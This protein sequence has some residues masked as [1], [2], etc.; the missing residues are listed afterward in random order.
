MSLESSIDRLAQAIEALVER[1]DVRPAPKSGS[2]QPETAQSDLD[3]TDEAPKARRG[4][5]PKAQTQTM[6]A[7]APAEPDEYATIAPEPAPTPPAKAAIEYVRDIQTP[8]LNLVKAKGKEA[9]LSILARFESKTARDVP[10]ARW[11]E[12]AAAI[13]EAL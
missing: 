9:F 7:A 10:E 8:A 3:Q 4:R 6:Q 11:P 2:E 1:M 5:K 12:L 13:A